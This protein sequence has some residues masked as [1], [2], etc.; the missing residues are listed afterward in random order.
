MGLWLLQE[1]KRRWEMDGKDYSWTEL[2]TLAEQAEPFRS[3]IDPDREAFLNPEDMPAAIRRFCRET[4]QPAPEDV[5]QVVRCCLDS[6]ALRYRWVLEA[7][8][9]LT[10]QRVTK[11]C[12][13]GG[14]SQNALLSQFTADACQRT[15]ITGPV[16]ATALGNIMIQAVATG[17]LPNITA[18]RQAIAASVEQE[19]YKPGTAGPWDIAFERFK[20]LL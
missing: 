1:C 5:G 4:G 18:G 10:G 15:V 8:E 11:I 19:T 17:H 2:L 13:V 16:E 3:L 6:L 20:G 12:I 9:A 7:L 14:G